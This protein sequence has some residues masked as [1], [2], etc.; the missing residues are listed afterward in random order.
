MEEIIMSKVNKIIYKEKFA[1][2]DKEN[3]FLA[4]IEELKYLTSEYLLLL[5]CSKDELGEYEVSIMGEEIDVNRLL[6]EMDLKEII[7]STIA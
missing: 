3:I 2:E 1:D 5:D 7:V 4:C 6:L